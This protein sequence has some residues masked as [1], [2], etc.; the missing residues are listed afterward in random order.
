[1]EEDEVVIDE[2]GVT[3]VTDTELHELFSV[4]SA[5]FASSVCR[6]ENILAGQLVGLALI[7]GALISLLIVRFFHVR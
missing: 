3:Y 4:Y 2:G 7:S 5:D 6:I 1:M